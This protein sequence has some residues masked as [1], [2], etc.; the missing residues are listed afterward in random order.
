[1]STNRDIAMRWRVARTRSHGDGVLDI[2]SENAKIKTQEIEE[3]T[4]LIKIQNDILDNLEIQ[5]AELKQ[6]SHFQTYSYA[7]LIRKLV[8]FRC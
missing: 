1:M 3:L 7:L 4:N 6:Q 2:L 8:L 5:I